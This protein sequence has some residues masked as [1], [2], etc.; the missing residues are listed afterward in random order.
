MPGR[1]GREYGCCSF[2]AFRVHVHHL[3]SLCEYFST[4][5]ELFAQCPGFRCIQPEVQLLPTL[6]CALVQP[7]STPYSCA[8]AHYR[9][10]V[11]IGFLVQVLMTTDLP[12]AV[13]GTSLISDP[14]VPAALGISSV[15]LEIPRMCFRVVTPP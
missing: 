4:N 15:L 9:Y 8:D 10:P 7:F 12:C 14:S 2:P 3:A 11:S 1:L 6:P 5:S 13:L